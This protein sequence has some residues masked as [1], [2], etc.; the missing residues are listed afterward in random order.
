[1]VL[2]QVRCPVVL[3]INVLDAWVEVKDV[4]VFDPLV[5]QL[6]KDRY[7][8]VGRINPKDVK[9]YTPEM[10]NWMMKSKHYGPWE[11][12]PTDFEKKF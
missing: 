3:T 11:V 4:F 8:L 12:E 2:L 5:N 7:Y 6:M 10:N 1:M 9:L